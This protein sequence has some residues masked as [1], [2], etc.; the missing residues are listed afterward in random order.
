MYSVLV[1]VDHDS[2]EFAVSVRNLECNKHWKF[3]DGFYFDTSDSHPRPFYEQSKA[4]NERIGRKFSGVIEAG[5]ALLGY[6]QIDVKSK[7]QA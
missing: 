2:K 6:E 3:K 5:F 4:P 1:N 7:E